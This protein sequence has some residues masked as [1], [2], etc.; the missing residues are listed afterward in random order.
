MSSEDLKQLQL[1]IDKKDSDFKQEL[2]A[3]KGKISD[4]EYQKIIG[5]HNQEMADLKNMLDREKLRME[6]KLKDKL[7]ARRRT[8][9]TDKGENEADAVSD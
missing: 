6:Q 7:A 4:K 3:K 5:K 9:D 2:K 8:A 1:L